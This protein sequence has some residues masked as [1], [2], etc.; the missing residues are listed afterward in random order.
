MDSDEREI[1][2]YLKSRGREYIPMRELSRHVGSKRRRRASPDWAR[3]FLLSMLERGILEGGEEAGFRIKPIPRKST[4][5]KRWA[6]PE[7][8]KILKASGKAFDNVVTAEDEDE[9]YERL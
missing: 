5:G 9:Y 6:S 2:Y 8:A 3:P 7:L 1:F 4:Q